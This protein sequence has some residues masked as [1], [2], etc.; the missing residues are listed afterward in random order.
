MGQPVFSQQQR[1]GAENHPRLVF[2]IGKLPETTKLTDHAI[3]RFCS[4]LRTQ[5]P[6]C[7]KQAGGFCQYLKTFFL[8]DVNPIEQV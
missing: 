6:G 3:K 1:S 7:G 5:N 8:V 4:G 2:E